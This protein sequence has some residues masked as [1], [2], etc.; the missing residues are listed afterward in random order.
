MPKDNEMIPCY[1]TLG[2]L[3]YLLGCLCT[4]EYWNPENYEERDRI[5]INIQGKINHE[6]Y[7]IAK[8]RKV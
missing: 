2:E 3:K 4:D 7:L 1:F 8:E 5:S 6:E